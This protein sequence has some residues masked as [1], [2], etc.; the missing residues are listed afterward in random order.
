MPKLSNS[1]EQ[2]DLFN[3]PFVQEPETWKDVKGF[4]GKYQISS[5]GRVK[6]LSNNKKE[7]IL[8]NG[9]NTTGYLIIC[10]CNNPYY[11]TFLVHRLMMIAFEK[12]NILNKSDVNHI[13]GNKLNNRLDNLEWNTRQENI[14]HSFAHDMSKK[15]SKHY[16]SKLQDDIIIEIRNKHIPYHYTQ[17]MLAEE[18]KVSEGTIQ[19]IIERRTWNHV[20]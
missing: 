17:K 12:P 3:L 10:L 9:I 13:D 18:Y 15:G 19:S 1:A 20:K 11:K 16:H 4:E 6:S 14:I 8:K 5:L 7:K 2:F